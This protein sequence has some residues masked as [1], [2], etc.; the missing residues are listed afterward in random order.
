MKRWHI[1]RAVAVLVAVCAWWTS[2]PNAL[3]EQPTFRNLTRKYF[4]D[5]D[6]AGL[7]K[8]VGYQEPVKKV[9][10]LEYKVLL[11]QDGKEVPVDPKTHEFK[12]GDKVRVSIEPLSDYYVYIYHIGASGQKGFLLPDKDEDPPL[13]KKGRPVALPDDGFLEFAPPPGEE[14]LLVVAMEKPVPD[15]AVLASILGKK[16]GEKDTPEEQALRKTLKATRKKVLKSVDET[17]KEILDHTV[18]W[19]GLTAEKPMRKLAE[20]IRTR[21]VKDG[22]FEEPTAHGTSALYMTCEEVEKGQAK[23]LVSIPLKSIGS[24]AKKAEAEQP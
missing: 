5:G 13:A 1:S 4:K 14:T 21:G 9:I 15:R 2:M 10:A 11:F 6:G 16:P 12:V 24:K 7:A 8:L 19:R 20:E 22:T 18:M 3:A 17:R 23:L